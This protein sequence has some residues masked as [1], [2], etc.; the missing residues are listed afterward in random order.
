[1]IES[2]IMKELE[3][4]L[5]GK[6]DD[7]QYGNCKGCSTTHY[8]IKLT[9]EAFISTD[10]G[11]ATTAVTIDYS[12]AFDYVDHSILIKKLVELEVRP[13]ITNIIISFLKERSHTTKSFGIESPYLNITCGVPQGTCSGPKL[14]VILI[15]GKK[16]NFVS[17]Y[18]FVDDKTLSHSYSGD[19]TNV[20]KRALEIEAEETK[21]D[22]MIIN[23]NKCHAIT[24][25]FSKKNTPPT[26]LSID[27]HII[28]NREKINLL[29]VVISNDLK[30]S[31]NTEH[32]CDKVNRK[33]Y[34]LGKLKKFGLRTEELLKVWKAVLRPLTEY[35]TPLWHSGLTD[36]DSEML[37]SLQKKV[38][39]IIL[40][41]TYINNKRRYKV[42]GKSLCYKMTL[43]KID[44][45][46]LKDRRE[47]L[48]KKF[49]LQVV[50]NAR[51]NEMFQPRIRNV[52]TRL[53]SKYQENF[54]ETNRFK[55]SAVPYMTRM[56]NNDA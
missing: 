46:S 36:V 21:K 14:F 56:L 49:A 47:F 20:I 19:P 25:N 22:K 53:R 24:F 30:W 11:N 31:D 42:D 44:L 8:L 32:I 45:E 7:D 1:M 27:G 28:Q 37:E 17:C 52:N 16:C 55:M 41:V 6:L 10:K 9:N 48:T 50:H 3:K 5:I 13:N 38:L 29:G 12:K 33:I 26:N 54:C 35:A 34:I 40:G 23:L 4:D 15:N 43:E 2:V 18:K 39:G 51:H